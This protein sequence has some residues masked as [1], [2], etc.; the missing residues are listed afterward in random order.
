MTFTD[1]RGARRFPYE[2]VLANGARFPEFPPTTV[3]VAGMI[4]P[5][6]GGGYLRLMP[7]S[8]TDMSFRQVRAGEKVIVYFHPWELDPEQPRIN[9]RL[10]SRFRHYTNL[11]QMQSRVVHLLQTYKFRPLLEF[12]RQ[13][14][15]EEYFSRLA[16]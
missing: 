15:R 3:K 13:W 2:H 6:A 12:T 10:R 9:A 16:A 7:L 8:Y 5:A 1:Y 4:L 11:A 14:R